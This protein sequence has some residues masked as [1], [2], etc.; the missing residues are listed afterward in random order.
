MVDTT[1]EGDKDEYVVRRPLRCLITSHG[2][3][4]PDPT[5][6]NRLSVW[7]T[8]GSLAL[9]DGSEDQSEEWKKLFDLASAPRRDLSELARVLAARIFVGAQLPEGMDE[10]GKMKYT[11]RR[12]IGGHGHVFL[13]VMYAD[14]SLRILKGQRGSI[15]VNAKIPTFS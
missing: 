11:L 7:F 5:T 10:D 2:Y 4:L 6:P 15:F 13:D 14:E 12:P 3:C 1:A 8:G 9:E